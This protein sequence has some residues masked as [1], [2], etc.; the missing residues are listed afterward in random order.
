MP[1]LFADRFGLVEIAH[2]AQRHAQDVP[3]AERHGAHVDVGE[4]AVEQVR[5]EARLA[6]AEHFLGNLAAGREA[7]AGQR[8]ACR[9]PRA[10]LNSSSPSAGASMMNPRSAPLTSIAE[11]STSDSTSSSTRP[12]PSARSPS[13]SAA[14]WRRSPIAVVVG[15]LLGEPRPI[16]GQEDHLRAAAAAE[17][18]A[19]AVHQRALGDLLAVDVGAVAR[20]PV[21]QDEVPF[22]ILTIS[23]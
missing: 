16:G 18:D 5:D 3:D 22:W 10:I 14:I 8:D 4:L 19:V 2:Q 13:S 6:G 9:A 21:A 11:S 20:R 12:V 7:A 23:A 17:P 15:G 1:S